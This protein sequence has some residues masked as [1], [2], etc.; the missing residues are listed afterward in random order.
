MSPVKPYFVEKDNV[1]VVPVCH[2][3]ME[4]ALC[5]KAAFD[6]IQP[7]CIAVELPSTLDDEV[8]RAVARFPFLSVIFYQSG[9][10]EFIY[11][12]IEPSDPMCEAVRCGLENKIPVHCIDLD[13]DD[14]PLIFDPM[15][16]SYAVSR[17]GLE[18]YHRLYEETVLS[19]GKPK[20]TTVQDERRESAMAYHLQQL[21]AQYRKI[22]VVCG[23]AHT[24]GLLKKLEK[25]QGLP[26]G[27]PV[28][29]DLEVFNPSPASLREITG[30]APFVIAAYELM[31]GKHN[32]EKELEEWQPGQRN[33]DENS[34]F[35][36]EK[37]EPAKILSFNDRKRQRISK[38]LGIPEKDSPNTLTEGKTQI[39]E[40]TPENLFPQSSA[41]LA[42]PDGSR[43]T[44]KTTSLPAEPVTVQEVKNTSSAEDSLGNRLFKSFLKKIF[45]NLMTKTVKKKTDKSIP[46][47]NDL[48]LNSGN[49]EASGELIPFNDSD[50][51]SD[52][53]YD[54]NTNPYI[55]RENVHKFRIS[56]D[57]RGDI[58]R[59]YDRMNRENEI[60]ERQ[61]LL[62][63]LF[64]QSS[65]YYLENVNE[66]IKG[67][68]MRVFMKYARNLA[69]LTGLLLPE[70]YH[71]IM[72][73]R[74]CA[75]DNFAYE[76]WD[77]STYYPWQDKSGKLPTIDIKADEV[78]LNGKKFTLRRKF[79][80]IRK[81]LMRLPFRDRKN[82]KNPGEWAEK[83]DGNWICSY[84]PEDITI[85]N[86]GTYLR[87]KGISILNEDNTR[88]LPFTTS[89]LDGLD[90]RE[91][92]RNWKD[93]KLYVRETVQMQGGVGS[94][95]IIFDEDEKN[96]RYP[97]K[98]TW[99]GEHHQESDMA[100]YSTHPSEKIVGPGIARCEYGG[101]MMSYPPG[102]VW[103]VW[104]DP[105][106]SNTRTKAEVLLMAAIEY[107]LEKNVVYVA[108][109]A[110]R[111]YFKN[112]ANRLNKRVIYI[113]I[114]QLSPVSLKKLR[115]FHVLGGHKVR[116]I[117]KDYVW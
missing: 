16:D 45:G 34:A 84:P 47:V 50:I 3:R 81:R 35:S 22:L 2:Y 104:S 28:R 23:M 88:V 95:V 100:L 26:L 106:Y 91:T 39:G 9:S 15:P 7:D 70:L 42:R 57:R 30:E 94:V 59:F 101:M 78:W 73:A 10:G 37:P 75:D 14:Y 85:E 77:L 41:F 6:E 49:T 112:F 29:H 63:N 108:A 110:P 21:S 93:R 68:Q 61:N 51:F 80:Y 64:R 48:L 55:K 109:K 66:E 79:P 117:A 62:V 25:P 67:W 4:F 36:Q 33:A 96:V 82:E 116:E 115:V 40:R 5:V 31:R 99:L 17:L 114:G 107:C 92:M 60:P 76:M 102:R 69:R 53:L 38:A 89:L 74:G 97:W 27:K 8:K 54:I 13:T 1:Y 83:F 43:E 11:F 90:L 52:W 12:P 71:I 113:P 24:D 32:I 58:L 98:L 65:A 86:Y 105:L 46:G 56:E 18:T 72:C 20:I 19:E 44:G 111:T 87:K 103:D